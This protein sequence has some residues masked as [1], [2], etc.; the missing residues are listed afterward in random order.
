MTWSGG[1]AYFKANL[2][3]RR[4]R[5]QALPRRRAKSGDGYPCAVFS[6]AKTKHY[7]AGCQPSAIAAA[8]QAQVSDKSPPLTIR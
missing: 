8:Q 1:K 3:P 5:P 2:E 4:Q 7:F 6:H